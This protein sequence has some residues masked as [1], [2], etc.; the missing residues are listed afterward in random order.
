MIE[1]LEGSDFEFLSSDMS[2]IVM[3]SASLMEILAYK[4]PFLDN[5]LDA[6]ATPLAGLAGVTVV[7]ITLQGTDPAIQWAFAIIAGGSTSIGIQSA[8]VAG[9]GLS[10]GLIGCCKPD[11][12]H[13]RG[14]ILLLIVLIALLAPFL[15]LIGILFAL[16][17]WSAGGWA[18]SGLRRDMGTRP[19]KDESYADDSRQCERHC[20][21][22]LLGC[23]KFPCVGGPPKGH[24]L[25]MDANI[26]TS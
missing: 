24:G 17:I 8:T 1:S 14:Y 3:G 2:L 7:A 9:R 11:F 19:Q 10:C 20:D 15:A 22:D 16:S 21:E 18:Q 23:R 26:T 6:V 12:L 4:V 5:A 13:G 25:R